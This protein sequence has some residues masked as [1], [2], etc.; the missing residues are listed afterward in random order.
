MI[1]AA[2]TVVA[3]PSK[4]S[5]QMEIW[6][7]WCSVWGSHEGDHRSCGFSSYEQC[8]AATRLEGMCFENI[9]GPKPSGA[10][11]P[12]NIYASKKPPSRSSPHRSK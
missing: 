8:M 10:A 1:L 12:A 7:P 6:Y 5:A 2:I 11:T 4:S 3:A 9:W